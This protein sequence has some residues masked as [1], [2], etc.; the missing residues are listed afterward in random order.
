MPDSFPL[1]VAAIDIGSN[2]IRFIAAEFTQPG[3]YA[4]LDQKRS[5]VRLGHDVFLTGTLTPEAIAAA[6]Q[7]LAGYRERLDTLDIEHHR[8]V[9][10]SAVRDS[11]NGANLIEA[12]T[13]AG[14][15]IETITGAE[16]ARLAHLAVRSR[17]DLG[18]R[19]WMTAD[20]G[21]GS[22]EVS[23]VDHHAI[24]WSESAGMGSVRLLEELAVSGDDPERFRRRLEEY[25]AT[26]RIPV[27]HARLAGFIATGGNIEALARLAGTPVDARGVGRLR[28]SE[29]RRIIET[30]ARLSYQERM[31]ELGLRPDRAD[32]ILPASMV[33]ERLASLA[34]ADEIL[35]PFVGIK[36]GI[37]LDLAEEIIPLHGSRVERLEHTAVAGAL[38]LGRRYRFDAAHGRHVADLASALFDQLHEIHGLSREDRR[39]LIVAAMLHDVGT[40][41]SHRR[42]HKHSHYIISESDL[43]G[44]TQQEKAIVANV[45]RYHRKTPPA[46]HHD[47]YMR[48]E[49]R[50]RI[51]VERLSAILRVADALDRERRQ[52]VSRVRAIVRDSRVSLDVDGSGDLL[53]ER[54][55]LETSAAPLFE[56]A[57][58]LEL[59]MNS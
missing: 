26:L 40:F 10:T 59:R 42:H 19:R 1:R 58:G 9:A 13:R 28:T 16:E 27:S 34:G 17:I 46:P 52:N 4:I 37:V 36:D 2:A 39:L 48:L 32:V 29:L 44:M 47:A 57:F 3:R 41:I 38:A 20:L 56:K 55:A 33:Y 43:P 53:L 35:V 25:T 21:G 15:H 50:D 18:R 12:A 51:R 23:I 54:W 45:A 22:V 49:E 24:Y 31:H 14:I 5:P 8:A 7:V 11:R 6:A 30:L